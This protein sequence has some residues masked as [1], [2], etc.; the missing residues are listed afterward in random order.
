MSSITTIVKPG[1]LKLTHIKQL[2]LQI[3]KEFKSSTYW[4][5]ILCP[6]HPV[7]L[8]LGLPVK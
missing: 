2:P 4:L 5:L 8:L 7:S 6:V 3:G 1:F